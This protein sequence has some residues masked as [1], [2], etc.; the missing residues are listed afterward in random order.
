[1]LSLDNEPIYVG[2]VSATFDFNTRR[3]ALVTVQSVY[4][5][6]AFWNG[7]PIV[8]L[9]SDASA[10]T[11]TDELSVF[12]VVPSAGIRWLRWRRSGGSTRPR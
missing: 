11:E 3:A 2:V 10:P 7:E 1:M 12:V 9:V 8:S 4:T 5:L 6:L